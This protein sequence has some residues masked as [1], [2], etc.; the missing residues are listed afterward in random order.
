MCNSCDPQ[1]EKST[2]GVD[3][4][5]GWGEEGEGVAR[6]LWIIPISNPSGPDVGDR[7]GGGG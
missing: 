4:I 1:R 6:D 5:H 3:T 7:G 2:G